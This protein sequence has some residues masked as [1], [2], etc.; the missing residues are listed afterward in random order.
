MAP[1]SE[2]R[3]RGV[4]V[5]SGAEV[6]QEM[7]SYCITGHGPYTVSRD[8]V[9]LSDSG[10]PEAC[11]EEAPLDGACPTCQTQALDGV[12]PRLF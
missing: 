6:G 2:R 8:M 11:A 7:E 3:R 4:D 1:G 9:P 12:G 10:M 5:I